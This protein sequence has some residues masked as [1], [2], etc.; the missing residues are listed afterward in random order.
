[1]TFFLTLLFT[2]K[3]LHK[4]RL[5]VTRRVSEDF[6]SLSF[7]RR[8]TASRELSTIRILASANGNS[9]TLVLVEPTPLR[10]A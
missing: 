8:V 1:M 6:F 5:L 3:V 4:H 2:K 10:L 7:A 9:E